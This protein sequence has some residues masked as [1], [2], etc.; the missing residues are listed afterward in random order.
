MEVLDVLIISRTLND[1]RLMLKGTK[2][3]AEPGNEQVNECSKVL[4][5]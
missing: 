2:K 4:F 3:N 1:I 5:Q